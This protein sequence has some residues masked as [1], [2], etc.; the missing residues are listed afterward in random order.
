MT[1][2]RYPVYH[3]KSYLSD[4]ACGK[5]GLYTTVKDPKNGDVM[6]SEDFFKLN[7][8]QFKHSAYVICGECWKAMV[9]NVSDI[10]YENSVEVEN[11]GS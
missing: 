5:V 2:V 3:N 11:N 8:K 9:I 6:R 1:V 7:G 10:D 4:T